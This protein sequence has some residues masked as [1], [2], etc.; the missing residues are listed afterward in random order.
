MTYRARVAT[1]IAR[2]EYEGFVVDYGLESATDD[3]DQGLMRVRV[4]G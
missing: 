4:N 2:P 3:I 1:D